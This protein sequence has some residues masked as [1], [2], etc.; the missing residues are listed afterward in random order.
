MDTKRKT[1]DNGVALCD[2]QTQRSVGSPALSG[3]L[4]QLKSKGTFYPLGCSG[5]LVSFDFDFSFEQKNLHLNGWV[6]IFSEFVFLLNF[7]LEKKLVPTGSESIKHT[8]SKF[9]TY[10][11]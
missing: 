1:Q 6:L 11:C 7:F 5:K 9:F 8:V 10:L 3:E 4:N 2:S